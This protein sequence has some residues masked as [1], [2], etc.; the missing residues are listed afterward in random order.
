[1]PPPPD[2]LPWVQQS[3]LLALCEISR[4]TLNSWVKAG[5]GL[6]NKAGYEFSDL[7]TLLIF[8]SARKHMSPQHMV[9]VWNDLHTEGEVDRLVEAAEHLQPG[10]NFDLVID[11]EYASFLVALSE[12]ELLDAVRHPLAPRPVVVVDMAEKVR[13]TAAAFRRFATTDEQPEQR[14]R[15]RPRNQARLRVVGGGHR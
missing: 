9:A 1:M 8:A 15:G 10:Q 7:V 3:R 4:A 11:P 2:E 14:K 12:P 5:L 13:D 6:G